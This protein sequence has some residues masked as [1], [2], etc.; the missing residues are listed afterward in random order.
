[1][2]RHKEFNLY[3]IHS[4]FGGKT[5]MLYKGPWDTNMLLSVGN[6]IRNLSKD[7][8]ALN[9]RIFKIFMEMAENI[10][11]YSAEFE[12]VLNTRRSGIGTF[13][14]REDGD[15]YYFHSGN[16]VYNIDIIPIIDKCGI[17]NSLDRES[18]RDFKR[19]QRNLP[20]G[21]RGGGNIGLIQ[22]ALSS[23]NP[24]DV[25]LTP[26]DDEKSFFAI[27]VHIDKAGIKEVE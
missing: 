19:R 6:Y 12:R 22:I 13:L 3:D 10:S 24:L 14:V 9:K 5:L 8:A 18:L 26:L 21:E 20:H 15:Y 2:T 1:M 27:C 7:D 11:L 16:V 23:N 17:I 4:T 25:Q